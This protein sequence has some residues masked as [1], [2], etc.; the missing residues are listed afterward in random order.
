M[1]EPQLTKEDQR[2]INE[3]N[4][5]H[6]KNKLYNA[7]I[8]NYTERLANLKDATYRCDELFGDN[9]KLMVG[10]TFIEVSEDTAKEMLDKLTKDRQTKRKELEDKY[11]NNKKRLDE[12]KIILYSKFKNAINLDE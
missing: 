12:L 4:R 2:Y 9:V 8:K 3:F 1:D 11:D 5:L 6:Q 10:E 7:E